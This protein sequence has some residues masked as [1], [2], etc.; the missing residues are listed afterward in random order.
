MQRPQLI[1]DLDVIGCDETILDHVQFEDGS[2]D[3]AEEDLELPD[4]LRVV[5]E[6][7][8]VNQRACIASEQCLKQLATVLASSL[9]KCTA[10]DCQALPPFEVKI[11]SKGTGMVIRWVRM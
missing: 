3:S 7:D 8:I 1:E 4:C 2:T 9:G 10:N 5:C 11:S 6:E